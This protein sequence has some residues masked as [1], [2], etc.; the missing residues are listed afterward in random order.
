MP[1]HPLWIFI[2]WQLFLL[3]V[4]SIYLKCARMLT[5][6]PLLTNIMSLQASTFFIGWLLTQRNFKLPWKQS[7]HLHPSS[8]YSKSC[9]FLSMRTPI[10]TMA[11][12]FFT[13]CN[14]VT[15]TPFQNI[16]TCQHPK[17]YYL[18]SPLLLL[19]WLQRA[20]STI[21][22]Q[23]SSIGTLSMAPHGMVLT[24]SIMSAMD[25]QSLYLQAP[26]GWRLWSNLWWLLRHWLP[27]SW[28]LI[29]P[30]CLMQQCGLWHLLPSGHAASKSPLFSLL[31]LLTHLILRL[32]E[33]LI[34]SPNLFNS[35]KHISQSA[36]PTCTSQ[37]HNG[38]EHATFYVPWTKT[39]AGLGADISIT[40]HNHVTCPLSALRHHLSANSLVPDSAPHLLLK[41]LMAVGH[42]WQNC[43]TLSGL[44]Q[45]F[46]RCQGTPFE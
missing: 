22:W 36:A 43:V 32:G 16:V 39:T 18:L 33:L 14:T 6:P 1:M 41:L 11:Q 15:L 13:S 29:F 26:S 28:A 12:V 21:G 5:L 17:F 38:M 24:C 35:A 7:S 9:S 46:L 20:C 34:P 45:V 42:Q 19:V 4:V 23:G 2:R 27:W 8:N 25:L 40:A 31:N 44:Q 3:M 10:A 30:M 37:V